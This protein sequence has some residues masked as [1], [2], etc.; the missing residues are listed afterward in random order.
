MRGWNLQRHTRTSEADLTRTVNPAGAAD[1]RAVTHD[2]RC[3]RVAS[4]ARETL[5]AG[6]V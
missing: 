4:V 3:N 6:Y 1:W 5:A 2:A